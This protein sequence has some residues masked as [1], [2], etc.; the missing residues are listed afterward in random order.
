[1]LETEITV[2]ETRIAELSHQIE[3]APPDK[4]GSLGEEYARVERDLHRRLD[5]WAVI[6]DQ[7]SVISHQ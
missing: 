2:L 5:E 4:V 6:S 7:S 3:K 1:E